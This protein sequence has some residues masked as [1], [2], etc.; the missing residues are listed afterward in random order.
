[1]RALRKLPECVHCTVRWRFHGAEQH[2]LGGRGAPSLLVATS[3]GPLFVWCSGDREA[4]W[5]VGGSA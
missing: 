3:N 4:G 2:A 1:M 5:R